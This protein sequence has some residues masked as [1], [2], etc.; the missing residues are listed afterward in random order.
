MA[1]MAVIALQCDMTRVAIVCITGTG[2][3]EI[4]WNSG[5]THHRVSHYDVGSEAS[6]V[7]YQW[8][9][10]GAISRSM[11]ASTYQLTRMTEMINRLKVRQTS[12]G[13][14]MLD[15]TAFVGLSEYSAADL[16]L[17]H[18]CPVITAGLGTS[19]G[20]IVTYPCKLSNIGGG[21]PGPG[22]QLDNENWVS[23]GMPRSST[24]LTRSSRQYSRIW[25]G[26]STHSPSRNTR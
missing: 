24:K 12:D 15:H 22:A 7:G 10:A 5:F 25:S 8:Q 13:Q 11:E 23:P 6:G 2:E 26:S 21:T 16:H 14:R 3:D 9:D 17:Q 18:Y 1:D 20:H 4:V 19:G